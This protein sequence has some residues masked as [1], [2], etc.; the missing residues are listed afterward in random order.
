MQSVEVKVDAALIE[1]LR[2]GYGQLASKGAPL[3]LQEEG[4][5]GW[6]PPRARGYVCKEERRSGFPS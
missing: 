4:A 5:G 1:Q 6:H 3:A 2:A